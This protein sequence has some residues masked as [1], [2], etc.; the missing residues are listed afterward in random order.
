[1]CCLSFRTFATAGTAGRYLVGG[2]TEQRYD[3]VY[4]VVVAMHSF[5]LRRNGQAKKGILLYIFFKICPSILKRK[6]TIVTTSQPPHG[7]KFSRCH[8]AFP[9]S[10]LRDVRDF[11]SSVMIIQVQVTPRAPPSRFS[12]PSASM[13]DIP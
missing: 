1:M 4:Y 3:A 12:P 8:I 5:I 7:D 6:T 2:S 9:L 13:S 11:F 10:L